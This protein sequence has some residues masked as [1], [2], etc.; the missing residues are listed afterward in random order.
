[1]IM[2][3]SILT[4]HLLILLILI[5]CNNKEIIMEN[6]LIIED[7]LTGEGVVAG[8]HAGSPQTTSFTVTFRRPRAGSGSSSS[9]Q[10]LIRARASRFSESRRRFSATFAGSNK[11]SKVAIY[12]VQIPCVPKDAS[13]A[14]GS[15]YMLIFV[16]CTCL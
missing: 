4:T 3:K 14:S 13:M 12:L 1:M 16:Q 11:P 9:A 2:S 10:A 6:G 5:G 8:A 15:G 7:K